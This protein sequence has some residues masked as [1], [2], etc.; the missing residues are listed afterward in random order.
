MARPGIAGQPN[1]G[2]RL[3]YDCSRRLCSDAAGRCGLVLAWQGLNRFLAP[4]WGPFPSL[5]SPANSRW[6]VAPQAGAATCSDSRG[7]IFSVPPVVRHQASGLRSAPTR[8][9]GP[10][11]SCPSA[12]RSA[13]ALY[14]CQ[15]TGND[16][17]H[18]RHSRSSVKASI[19]VGSRGPDHC[20]GRHR[21]R[22]EQPAAPA[23]M[24]QV[25]IDLLLINPLFPPGRP[26]T[27]AESRTRELG[28]ASL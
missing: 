24:R 14:G 16:R 22:N 1:C 21:D 6:P 11:C 4:N 28:G 7:S 20:A 10:E 2:R 12:P 3:P 13:G 8:R 17:R 27:R 25:I 23:G 18:G 26:R 19:A 15:L 5:A 9:H